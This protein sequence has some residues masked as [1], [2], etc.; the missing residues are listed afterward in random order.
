MDCW[1]QSF[2]AEGES[3]VVEEAEQIAVA[4]VL[5]SPVAQIG[6]REQMVSAEDKAEVLAQSSDRN[7]NR[8]DSSLVGCGDDS[9]SSNVHEGRILDRTTGMCRG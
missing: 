6:C 5:Q 1:A 4:R 2:E 7:S 3:S 9:Q 8:R